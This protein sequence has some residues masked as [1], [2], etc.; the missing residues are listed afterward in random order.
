V[1]LVLVSDD[2]RTEKMVTKIVFINK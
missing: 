2:E 1:Y